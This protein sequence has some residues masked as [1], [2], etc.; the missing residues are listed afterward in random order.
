MSDEH[1]KIWDLIEKNTLCMLVTE[2][3]PAADE[4]KMAARPMKAIPERGDNRIW[5]FTRL[6]SGKTEDLARDGTVC[7]AFSDPSKGDYVS[8]TGRAEV[9]QDREKIKEHWGTFVDAWFPEGPDGADVGL[10]RVVPEAGQY[11][12]NP[13]SGLVAQVKTALASAQD[14]LPNMGEHEKVRFG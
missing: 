2:G 4:P 7:L 1:A 11:W 10:I 6:S 14:R 8:I 12:E 5:L 9:T 3:D 13:S